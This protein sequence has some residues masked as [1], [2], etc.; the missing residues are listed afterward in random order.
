MLVSYAVGGDEN[1]VEFEVIGRA[2][3][4]RPYVAFGLSDDGNMVSFFV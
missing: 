4:S 3:F 2:G 1:N